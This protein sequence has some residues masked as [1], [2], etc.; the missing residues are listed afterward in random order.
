MS[1]SSRGVMWAMGDLG[2]QDM[3]LCCPV[4]TLQGVKCSSAL[5]SVAAES[6]RS[7]LIPTHAASV[8]NLMLPFY[9]F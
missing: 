7:L 8:F 9:L 5:P 1:D 2:S 3:D 4:E 6:H